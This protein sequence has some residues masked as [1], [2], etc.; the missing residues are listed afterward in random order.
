MSGSFASGV[1]VIAL[2]LSTGGAFALTPEQQYQQELD[3]YHAQQSEYNYQR[4]QYDRHLDGYYFARNHP[5]AWWQQAYFRAAPDWYWR[6]SGAAL[7]GT[8]VAERD[9]RRVGEVSGVEHA[10]DGHIDRVQIALNDH[11]STWVNVEHIRFDRADRIAFVDL[12]ETELYDRANY[13]P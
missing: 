5:R 13:R 6:P 10:P 3:R 9:G 11:D 8:E 1:V 2:S 7:V 12:D 4:E